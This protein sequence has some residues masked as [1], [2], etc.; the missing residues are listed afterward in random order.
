MNGFVWQWPA[1]LIVGAVLLVLLILLVLWLTR[2]SA[3][4]PDPGR[5]LS[6]E[7]R[8]EAALAAAQNERTA[9]AADILNDTGKTS[10]AKKEK[11][12]LFIWGLK[13]R[14]TASPS[15]ARY[16]AYRV[17]VAAGSVVACCALVG[18]VCLAARPSTVVPLSSASSSRDIVLCLDV[19]GSALPF[20]QQVIASYLEL[21]QNF[22]TERIG[23]SIFNST[24][25]TVFPLTDDYSLV[26]QELRS[27]LTALDGVSTQ[28]SI[29]NMTPKQYQN[30]S[31]FLSGTQDRKN[32]TSLIGDGLVSCEA[33]FPG[34]SASAQTTQARVSP[35]SIVLATDNVLSGAPIYTLHQAMALAKRNSIR[36]DGL[37]TGDNQSLD[38][39]TT[40]EFRQQVEWEGGTFSTRQNGQSVDQLVH[41]IE[42]QKIEQEAK[43]QTVDL[44]DQPDPWILILGLLFAVLFLVMGWVKR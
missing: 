18:S 7:K 37:Y 39:A 19:S 14:V 41:S 28:Q 1:V 34:F 3:N 30:I 22:K 33:M 26:K 2:R 40:S 42:K 20:D 31:N 4:K 12:H 43:E 10:H 38:A 5:L 44:D 8:L 36:V 6:P 27:A 25:K 21:V 11:H 16:R 23:M 9:S 35:A 15:A 29:N 13:G 17:G 24:S 32:A